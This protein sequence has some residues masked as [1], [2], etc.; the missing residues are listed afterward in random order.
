MDIPFRRKLIFFAVIIIAIIAIPVLF[1]EIQRPWQRLE[2][3][4]RTSTN[5]LAAVQQSF[6]DSD[7]QSMQQFTLE[8]AKAVETV[9]SD[10]YQ[11]LDWTFS[12]YVSG[13]P[14][15]SEA[16]MQELLATK[17][18]TDAFDYQAVRR[19]YAYWE[20]VFSDKPEQLELFKKYKV[21]L[22]GLVQ[23]A[24]GSGSR[25]ADI[26]LLL[27]SGEQQ[28]TFT[29]RIYFIL[30]GYQ[31]YEDSAFPGD[32]YIM[33]TDAL[34]R[35]KAL[36]GTT[37]FDHNRLSDPGNWFLPGFY[38]D[39]WGN[40][41]SVWYTRQ[42]GEFYTLFVIDFDA[43]VVLQMMRNIAVITAALIFIVGFTV[44]IITT[45]LSKRYARSPLELTKGIQ[46]VSQGLYD[47][48]VP[49][50]YDEFRSVGEQFNKMVGKLRER[51]RL[52]I[53]LERMLSKELA[54]QA[55]QKGLM[56]GGE[57]AE[58]TI[59]FTDFAGFSTLTKKMKPKEVVQALNEYFEVLIPIIKKHGGFPDKYI[60]DAIV[61]IFGAPLRTVDHAQR[62]VQCAI[63]M[64]EALRILNLQRKH[65]QQVVFEMRI[66]L[67][68]G[69]VLVGAIGC[70]MKLEYTS[71]GE[72]TN[73]AQRMET[74]CPIGDVVTSTSTYQ[75]LPKSF[76][77]QLPFLFKKETFMVKGYIRGVSAYHVHLSP[78]EIGKNM[79]ARTLS[80]FYTYKPRKKP[81]ASGIDKVPG[82]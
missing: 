23:Q 44:V 30:D 64:Q 54:E 68:T 73:L 16:R 69:N 49:V 32:P 22:N 43:T 82:G 15:P 47:Y 58:C 36:S 13:S 65:E 34:L 21:Y 31:W 71:I 8:Q 6:P 78:F 75:A 74:V 33:E 9:P 53:V 20:T 80:T 67:N 63:E 50:L 46:A 61:A 77:K 35:K 55:A 28:G 14:L 38:T 72:T 70:D 57:E 59:M 60:G 27:D 48:S 5:M 4:I 76:L 29:D 41:F 52:Q 66:G 79:S 1:F 39:Q 45:W 81:G 26:Y 17:N 2:Q 19:A 40:W 42:T 10:V 24:Q 7:L 51:D 3:S 12:M 62:A 25:I 11:Y 37:G 18:N 56:L